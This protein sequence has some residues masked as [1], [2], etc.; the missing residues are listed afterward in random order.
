MYAAVAA[1]LVYAVLGT[2]RQL[3]VGPDASSALLTATAIAPLAMTGDAA[4][5]L[6][7]A[8]ALAMTIGL[9]HVAAGWARLGFVADFPSQLV[10]LGFMTG[11]ALIII[12]S[13]AGKLLGVRVAND[14]FFP[15]V[16]ELGSRLGESH[17]LTLGIGLTSISAL[18]L[19]R[20]LVPQVPAPL[21]VVAG[22]TAVVWL[23][24]FD[25]QGTAI[26][27]AVPTG[28]P[29]PTLPSVT[30]HE[31]RQLLPA[32]GSM[33][34]LSFADSVLTARSFAARH[35]D[36]VDASQEL[37]ALGSANLGA[38]LAGGFPISS[39]S[40][41]TAVNDAS[42]GKSQLAGVVAA[43]LA[44]VFLLFFAPVLRMLPLA[45]LAAII[46]DAAAGLV[47]VPRMWQLR[48]VSRREY[49]VAI[50]TLFG[51]LVVGIL[52]GILLA[53]TASLLLV[54]AEISR[55]HTAVLGSQEAVDGFH[56]I[57]RG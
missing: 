15:R 43:T 27:G 38:G 8:G 56:E 18:L 55:P 4:H 41:R 9:V 45:A 50:L 5:Y 6:A 7:L 32:A 23:G 11:T 16:W 36:T 29:W 42:G 25:R 54:I 13:Q 35:G 1:M 24:A 2:S 12:A 49:Y 26:V 57:V 14:D 51:V 37:V 30:V 46:M 40:S 28:L 34:L 44:I 47:D 19:L 48:T 39:S 33:A 10:L 31:L 3:V 20:R 17:P 22:S 53:A 21:V 52:P